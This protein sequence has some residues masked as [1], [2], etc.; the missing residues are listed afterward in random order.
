MNGTEFCVVLCLCSGRKERHHQVAEQINWD[1][2]CLQYNCM[3]K[4][5]ICTIFLFVVAVAVAVAT[6]ATVIIIIVHYVNVC[7]SVCLHQNK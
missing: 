7:M 5:S 2:V 6:T 4:H 1:G 3:D